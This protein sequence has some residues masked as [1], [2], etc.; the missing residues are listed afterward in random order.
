MK[1]I[2][3]YFTLNL[4][5]KTAIIRS[6]ILVPKHTVTMSTCCTIKFTVFIQKKDCILHGQFYKSRKLTFLDGSAKRRKAY[7]YN[8]LCHMRLVCV[9]HVL[10]VD[11]A[12]KEAYTNSHRESES[13]I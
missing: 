1:P 13:S 6:V 9:D 5:C 10:A 11:E 2:H 3:K 12:K 4:V 7:H 8:T